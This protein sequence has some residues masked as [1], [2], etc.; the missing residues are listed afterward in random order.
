MYKYKYTKKLST[1]AVWKT[2]KT[3]IDYIG[4]SVF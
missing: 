1:L 2:Y 3:N 4:G